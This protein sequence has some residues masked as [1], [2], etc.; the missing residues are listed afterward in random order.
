MAVKKT[1]VVSTTTADDAEADAK[2][3]DDAEDRGAADRERDD[4][5][6]APETD[7]PYMGPAPWAGPGV[8][9]HLSATTTTADDAEA[10]ATAQR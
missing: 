1:P 4:A 3:K 7:N 6:D 9:S 8:S 2:R 10:D 5:R